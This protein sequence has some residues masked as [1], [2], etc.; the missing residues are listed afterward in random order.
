MKRVAENSF[1]LFVYP[2]VFDPAT[3]VERSAAISAA[4]WQAGSHRIPVWKP[5]R[6]PRGDMLAYVAGYLNPASGESPTAHLWRMNWGLRR[7][8]GLSNEADWALG[9]KRKGAQEEFPFCFGE[10]LKVGEKEN[11]NSFAFRLALFHGGVGFLT[12]QVTPRSDQVEDWLDFTHYFRFANRPNKVW[13]QGRAGQRLAATGSGAAFFPDSAGGTQ[14]HSDGKGTLNDLLVALL[15]TG[16]ASRARA[17]A[18]GQVGHEWWT[19]VFV[20]EQVIPFA[21]FFVEGVLANEEMELAYKLRSFFHRYQGDDPAPEDLSRDQP[22]LLP[23]ANRQWFIFSVEGGAFLA[24]DAPKREFFQA[25]LPAHIRS[26]YFLVFMLTLQQRFVLMS[27]SQ[28]VADKWLIEGKSPAE[29]TEGRFKAFAQI[30]D[31]FLEFTA[32]GYFTQVMQREHHQRFYRKWQE[33]FQIRDLYEEVRDEVREMYQ[34]LQSQRT[35]AEEKRARRFGI[36]ISTVALL[37]VIP[38]IVFGFLG[39]NIRNFTSAADTG[40]TVRQALLWSAVGTVGLVLLAWGV[41]EIVRK[42]I[43]RTSE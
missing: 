7:S 2:F 25:T 36:W 38:T 32:R 17:E 40:L 18:A 27:L 8:F 22:G 30:R 43:N 5:D 29:L 26:H 15:A 13:L 6:F 16:D 35:E 4:E 11:D 42:R 20:P 41:R 39:I 14:S 19:E 12:C 37:V 33:V 23:Y 31:R 34:Y 24:C 1:L 10:I 21:S 3:F 9:I 28:K